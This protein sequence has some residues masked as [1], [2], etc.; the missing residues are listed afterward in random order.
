[1]ES[2]VSHIYSRPD[3][4]AHKLEVAPRART[5]SFVIHQ[6]D[7][8]R[9]GPL[10]PGPAGLTSH[11]DSTSPQNTITRDKTLTPISSDKI[12]FPAVKH[13][14]NVCT[15]R[16]NFL[17]GVRSCVATHAFQMYPTDLFGSLHPWINTASLIPPSF[18]F[19]IGCLR[20]CISVAMARHR[21]GYGGSGMGSA[22][23]RE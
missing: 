22:G 4:R 10:H 5:T 9:R 3:S 7:R 6:R 1:M 17:H 21:L 18:L 16:F 8:Q 2:L 11:L 12:L 14:S 15:F 19:G 23:E 13:A 20:C